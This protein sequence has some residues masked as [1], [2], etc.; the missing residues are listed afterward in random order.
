MDVGTCVWCIVTARFLFTGLEKNREGKQKDGIKREERKKKD[1]V[2][3]V[4]SPLEICGALET[5]FMQLN[6]VGEEMMLR[7]QK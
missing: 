5:H 6:D 3:D 2:Y 4:M 7:E 1:D